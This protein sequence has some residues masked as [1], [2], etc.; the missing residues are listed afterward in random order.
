MKR[1]KARIQ[2]FMHSKMSGE[3]TYLFELM[4]LVCPVSIDSHNALTLRVV[5]PQMVTC[6][7]VLH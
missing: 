4:N 7:F 6:L 5:I 2:I 1:K 3:L